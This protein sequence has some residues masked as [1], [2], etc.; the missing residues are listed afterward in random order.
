[1]QNLISQQ[2]DKILSAHS[3]CTFNAIKTLVQKML[4]L[5][6][7]LFNYLRHG[8]YTKSWHKVLE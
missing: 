7:D 1:M 4:E 6:L 8:K 2:T 5:F 3:T